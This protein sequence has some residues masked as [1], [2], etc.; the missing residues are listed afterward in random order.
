[1]LWDKSW[2]VRLQSFSQSHIDVRVY[3]GVGD[4]NWRF[5]GFY[6]DPDRM[7]RK[8][9]WRL[10]RHLSNQWTSQWLVAG[11][12]NEILSQDEHAGRLPR[13]LWQM[14]DFREALA[15]ADLQDL[16]FEG[17]IHT[18]YNKREEPHTLRLRSDRACGNLDWKLAFPKTIS[19]HTFRIIALS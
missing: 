9:S 10:L 12:F 17:Y 7:K 3:Q 18:W 5:T 11:D 4:S 16:A 2:D 14:R 8:E 15:D 1:M 13:P 19:S 6:G